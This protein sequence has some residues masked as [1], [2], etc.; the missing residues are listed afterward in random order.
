MV[1][2]S[3]HGLGAALVRLRYGLGQLSPFFPSSLP[4]NSPPLPPPTQLQGDGWSSLQSWQRPRDN[5]ITY[6]VL[7]SFAVYPSFTI[8]CLVMWLVV[9]ESEG[10]ATFSN[11]DGVGG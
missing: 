4:L 10:Y 2:G 6:A 8:A 5:A 3:E 9:S 1:G 7:A 11:V